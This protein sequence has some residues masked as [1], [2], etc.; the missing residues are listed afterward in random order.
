M[1]TWI[2]PPHHHHHVSLLSVFPHVKLMVTQKHLHLHLI[3]NS[4]FSLCR[5]KRPFVAVAH[6]L[7]SCVCVW[8][9]AHVW[10]LTCGHESSLQWSIPPGVMDRSV[11]RSESSVSSPALVGRILMSPWDQREDGLDRPG[12]FS[13]LMVGQSFTD[14][15]GQSTGFICLRCRCS[16]CLPALSSLLWL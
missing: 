2:T 8:E 12:R 10:P 16:R 14:I 1:L 7:D 9:R 3:L 11:W 5:F 6:M 15:Q 13:C 4:S